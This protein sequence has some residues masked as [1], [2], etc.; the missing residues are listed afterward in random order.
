[1]E[2]E[3]RPIFVTAELC[4]TLPRVKDAMVEGRH[5]SLDFQPLP[6]GLKY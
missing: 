2:L 6:E 5:F 4:R 3:T 1:M